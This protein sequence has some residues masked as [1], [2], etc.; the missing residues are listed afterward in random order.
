MSGDS[1]SRDSLFV[2]MM[3]AGLIGLAFRSLGIFLDGGDYSVLRILEGGEPESTLF[4]LTAIITYGISIS[5][6]GVM[7]GALGMMR[8]AARD[9]K[10]SG[11]HDF[12][13]LRY[14]TKAA[15][16]QFCQYGWIM[17]LAT[18]ITLGGLL[19][20]LVLCVWQFVAGFR[21]V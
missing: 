8:R 13:R 2:L 6:L 19:G 14:H 21:P 7:L 20:A 10:S 1:P 9:C 18:L 11:T 5:C 3:G 12:R 15:S 16:G 17:I 4:S